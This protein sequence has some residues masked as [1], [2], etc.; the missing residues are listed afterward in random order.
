[1][2]DTWST[3]PRSCCIWLTSRISVQFR[4]PAQIAQSH[5]FT[6]RFDKANSRGRKP[7][8][9]KEIPSP[10][11]LSPLV[12]SYGLAVFWGSKWQLKKYQFFSPSWQT[13]II[14][15]A[16]TRVNGVAKSIVQSYTTTFYPHKTCW[17]SLSEHSRDCGSFELYLSQAIS[18]YIKRGSRLQY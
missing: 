11:H 8:T 18:T 2:F 12:H 3:L 4:S 16:R 10:C 15:I 9:S 6:S 14:P 5:R 7:N 17:F 13:L 1:M